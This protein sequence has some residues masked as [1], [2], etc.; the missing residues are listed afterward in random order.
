MIPVLDA[1]E[2]KAIGGIALAAA[3]FAGYE[4]IRH[5][6]KSEGIAQCQATYAAAA[7][8]AETENRAKEQ[9]MQDAS[10]ENSLE[11]QRLAA[12]DRQHAARLDAAAPRLLSALTASCG[13][14]PASAAAP[15]GSA[16]APADSGVRSDVLGGLVAA[17]SA[18]GRYADA[19]R[20]AGLGCQRAPREVTTSLDLPKL[21]LGTP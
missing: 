10:H 18:V 9:R 3:L 16:A 4:Y 19:S 15:A 20:T 1:L 7:I 5:E 12:L 8:K 14:V 21:R 13:A 2:L 6:A 11:T 17:I